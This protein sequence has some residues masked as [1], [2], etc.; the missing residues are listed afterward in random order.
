M[1][2]KT[3]LL[4][5][6][7]GGL[8]ICLLLHFLYLF[9]MSIRT[10]SWECIEGVIVD[11]RVKRSTNVDY[12][13]AFTLKVKYKYILNDKEIISKRVFFGDFIGANF[14][15]HYKKQVQNYNQCNAINVYYNPKKPVQSVLEKGIHFI[16]F[17]ELIV[18]IIFIMLCFM[19][20]SW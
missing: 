12:A 18:G 3:F 9:F 5:I 20:M 17:R 7:L 14:S 11:A 8:G 15:N 6:L 4:C 13:D 1:E 16:I 19:V 2:N 10:T